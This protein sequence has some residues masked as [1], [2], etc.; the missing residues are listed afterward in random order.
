MFVLK[1]WCE[2]LL[3]LC[4]SFTC[5]SLEKSF[6]QFGLPQIGIDYHGSETQRPLRTRIM[7]DQ[8]VSI[9]SATFVQCYL[10]FSIYLFIVTFLEV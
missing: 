2:V 6:H 7:M 8:S 10:F 9:A 4:H 3:K 1:R 5:T